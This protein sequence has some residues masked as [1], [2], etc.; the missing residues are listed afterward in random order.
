MKKIL[1]HFIIASVSLYLASNFA[2]GL[3]FEKGIETIV[4]TGLALTIASLIVKPLVNILILPINLLTFGLFRW[5]SSAVALYLI[6]LITPG[7]KIA[8]FSFAGFSSA[9]FDLPPIFLPGILGLVAFSFLISFI[10][11]FSFWVFKS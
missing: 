7:F 5:V 6:T 10:S 2:K 1:R 3:I 11:S 9:W 8:G 4:I